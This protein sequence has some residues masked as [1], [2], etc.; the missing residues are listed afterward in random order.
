MTTRTLP[1]DVAAQARERSNGSLSQAA[2]DVLLVAGR[3]L[4]KLTRTP[5]LIVF[6]TIQPVMF[7]LLF[8]YVF[9]GVAGASVPFYH[10]FIVPTVMVQ[11]LTFAASASG[12]GLANDLQSGMIDRFRALPIARSAVLLGRALSDAVRIALQASLLLIVAVLIGFRFPAGIG[13]G[14]LML[15]IAVLFGVGLSIFSA[16][17]GLTLKDPETVQVAGFVPIFPLIFASSGFSPVSQLPGWMQGFARINPV[18][19]AVDTMRGLAL[20]D[21]YQKALAN[22]P[23]PPGITAASFNYQRHLGSSAIHLVLW[24]VAI[25]VVFTTLAVRQYRK[26]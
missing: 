24:L 5:Q 19:A 18:T 4:R 15:I 8:S 9:G 7:L 11:T 25:V 13:R 26:V 20:G 1:A 21:H 3:N 23:L 2:G 14:L 22:H 17:I 10:S 16:W 12:V 6:S